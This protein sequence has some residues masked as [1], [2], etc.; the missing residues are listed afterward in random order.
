MSHQE[1][2]F[3]GWVCALPFVI[4]AVSVDLG[5][6]ELLVARCDVK[7]DRGVVKETAYTAGKA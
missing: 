5:K 7:N 2:G 6:R 3:Q 1:N 4:Q